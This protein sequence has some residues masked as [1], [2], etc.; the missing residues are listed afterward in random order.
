MRT[1]ANRDACICSWAVAL[2]L[3]RRYGE[4]YHA[5]GYH[6]AYNELIFSAR[7]FLP[8]ETPRLVI[9][10]S[11]GRRIVP[12]VHCAADGVWEGEAIVADA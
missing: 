11:R 8:R 7:K 12:S 2:E 3:H 1:P 5:P 6:S 10:V 4:P 9:L